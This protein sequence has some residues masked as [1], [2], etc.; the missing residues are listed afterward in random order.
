MLAALMFLFIGMVTDR[1][2]AL[3]LISIE[4][5]PFS[6]LDGRPHRRGCAQLLTGLTLEGEKGFGGIS[7]MQLKGDQLHLLSDAG[8]IFTGR[9]TRNEQGL[10]TDLTEMSRTALV[11][12]K[13]QALK[14]PRSDSEAFILEGEKALISFEADDRIQWMH[15]HGP[16]WHPGEVIYQS[17]DPLFGTNQGI[18]ALT[19]L[20][21]G[22]LLAVAEAKTA[23]GTSPLLLGAQEG[24][25][26]TWREAAYRAAPDFSVT[27]AATDPK[28]GDVYI[29]ERAF[30]WRRGPR[31]RL[32]R[33]E[34]KALVAAQAGD[35][36]ILE[37]TEVTRLS[38]WDGIDIMEGLALDRNPDGDLIVHLISDD[39]YK[40][41]Q[42]TVLLGIV[43]EE[44]REG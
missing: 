10:V 4:A 24:G 3:P 26:W 1:D 9:V 27:D 36:R 38:F 23:E 31:A 42:R 19:Q 15:Q 32:V 6:T 7:A 2:A 14:R 25:A 33:L 43:I 13:G 37:G 39:N 20:K 40:N 41:F 34:A 44:G 8:M 29:L 35:I 30:R 22:G 28:T 12:E 18:E 16:R 21:N 17:T 11:D 5:T